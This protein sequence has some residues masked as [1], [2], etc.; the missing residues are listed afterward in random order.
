[1]FYPDFGCM[2]ICFFPLYKKSIPT[3]KKYAIEVELLWF[4]Q[5]ENLTVYK[6]SFRRDGIHQ[7]YFDVKHEV[8]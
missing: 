4:A 8:K 6:S 5:S 3:E 2:E 7:C 1:M